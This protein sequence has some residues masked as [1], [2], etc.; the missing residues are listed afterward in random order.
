[1]FPSIKESAKKYLGL[2][3]KESY[4]TTQSKC[5]VTSECNNVELVTVKI[6]SSRRRIRY[7]L[8]KKEEKSEGLEKDSI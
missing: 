7:D 5:Q 6:R 1:M 4:S 3:T 8:Q 2:G